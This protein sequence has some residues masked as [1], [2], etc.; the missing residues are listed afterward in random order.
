MLIKAAI[1]YGVLVDDVRILRVWEWAD[2]GIN[3]LAVVAAIVGV[4]D[5]AIGRR[6]LRAPRLAANIDA[7]AP[8][9]FG[10]LDANRNA[11]DFDVNELFDSGVKGG[12]IASLIITF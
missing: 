11:A 2:E 10:I 1:T 5:E 8:R 9:A 4:G 6:E 7:A 12:A 3:A